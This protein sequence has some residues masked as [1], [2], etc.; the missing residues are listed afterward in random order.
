MKTRYSIEYHAENTYE[1]PFNEANWQFLIQ[2]LDDPGQRLLEVH[3]EN[4][5]NAPWEPSLN[6]FGFEVIRIRCRIPVREIRFHAIFHLEKELV[7]PY[8]FNPASVQPLPSLPEELLEFKVTHN[9]Y[10]TPTNLTRLPATAAIFKFDSS[11]NLFDNLLQL[12]SWVYETLVYKEGV[13]HTDTRL[14]ELLE[15]NQGVCQDFS[16]LFIGMARA[17]G[18]PSRYVS[19]Y[20]HQGHGYFGDTQMHAWA[21]AFLPGIGWVGFD[22]TNNLLAA[23]DHVKVAHGRDYRDCAPLKGVIYGLGQNTTTHKVQVSSQQ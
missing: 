14:E 18:I 11:Q 23:T 19:G 8:D 13:T 4:S 12:N 1:N 3:F 7:N 15:K 9:R 21:E 22:P 17:N 10:L 6:A 5:A 20:L 16:H 2:P